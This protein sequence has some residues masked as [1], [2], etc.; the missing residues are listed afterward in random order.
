MKHAPIELMGA[1]MR[2]MDHQDAKGYSPTHTVEGWV[3]IMQKEMREVL[4]A[5]CTNR[6]D[7]AALSEVLQVVTVGMR[8]LMEHGVVERKRA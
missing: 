3:L 4:D 1:I 5:W 8:C 7:E 6:G 2:E